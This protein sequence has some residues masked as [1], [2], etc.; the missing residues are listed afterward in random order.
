M[1]GVA[2]SLLV[3]VAT[4]VRPAAQDPAGQAT[5]DW[6]KPEWTFLGPNLCSGCHESGQAKNAEQ[7]HIRYDEYRIWAKLDKHHQAYA[8][9]ELPGTPGSDARIEAARKRSKQMGEVLHLDPAKDPKCVNCH[10]MN[11]L[12][13]SR[14]PLTK[15][16]DG[17]TCDG[18]HGAASNWLGTHAAPDW[19]RKKPEEKVKAGMYPIWDPVARAEMCMSCHLGNVQEGKVLEH[20]FYAAGHPP[21]PGLEL[22]TF[23]QELPTHWKKRA[24]TEDEA[25]RR[26]RLVVLGGVAVFRESAKFLRDTANHKQLWP[27]YAFFECYA[28]HHDLKGDGENPSWRAGRGHA[29]APGRPQPRAWPEAL[30]RAAV[31]QAGADSKAELDR[32]NAAMQQLQG[33]FNARPFGDPTK[34]AAAADALYKWS[35]QLLQKLDTGKFDRAAAESLLRAIS[36][37]AQGPPRDFDSI[38]QLYWAFKATYEQYKDL[39]KP[40]NHDQIAKAIT[41]VDEQLQLKLPS[42]RDRQIVGEMLPKTLK[43]IVTYEA[44]P[45]VF[46]KQLDDLGKA[47]TR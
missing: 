14:R 8:V 1:I 2:V 25:A 46:Q 38:R 13:A 36:Q 23:S 12:P 22:E 45:K 9:L 19:Y 26:L 29:G 6:Q 3:G 10:S 34:V 24:R 15:P 30:V 18:C 40:K 32:L 37:D 28:C 17:V 39:E 16:E 20:R 4:T 21:L 31:A 42:G 44:D 5:Y 47:L 27:D 35:G 7:N 43:A 41:K 33:S 11:W